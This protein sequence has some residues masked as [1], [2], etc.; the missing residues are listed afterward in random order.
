MVAASLI[1]AALLG[2][3][4]SPRA[5]VPV[6]STAV[7]AAVQP[8]AFNPTA[9][10]RAHE[11]SITVTPTVA[12]TLTVTVETDMGAV[13]ETLANAL[14]VAAAAPVS[15]TWAAV[16]AADGT[17]AIH[18]TLTDVDG[19]V[20]HAVTPVLVDTTAPRVSLG[21]LQPALTKRGPV[22]LRAATDDPSGAATIRVDIA[23][24]LDVPI[25]STA[26]TVDGDGRSGTTTWNLRLRKRLLLPGVFRLRATLTDGAGNIGTSDVR[27]LRVRRAV[28]TRVIYS[29]PDAGNVIGLS[30]DDCGS[31]ADM[32]RIVDAFRRAKAKTTFF[33]N[34]VNVRGNVSADRA[35][36]AAGNTIGSHTWS[37]PELPRLSYAD[38]LSQIEGD[39]DIWWRTAK[40][41]PAP[42]FR[43]PYGLRDAATLRAVGDAGFAWLVLWN[44]DPSDY[45]MPAR[46]EL[47]RRVVK[48]ARPG[49]I[50][51]LHANANTAAAVPELIR[52]LRAKGLEPE[53]LD[54]MFGSAAYLAPVSG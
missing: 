18:A 4:F 8:A 10:A 1:L 5:V 37:H 30:F 41:S 40:A 38:Q 35:A 49:A 24:Q 42:Y 34:G 25:G 54:E 20:S 50:V 19:A 28:Q 46:D 13:V 26:L 31:N 12:G 9:M 3:P 32:Q 11:A 45:L 51:V 48:D 22:E 2:A 21:A 43:P 29:L 7:S 33:C 27:L 6:S 14:P 47:V 39:S 44:V 52:A 16:G 23:S 15:L 36:L 53:S 17:Y